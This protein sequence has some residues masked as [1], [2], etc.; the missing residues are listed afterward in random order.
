MFFVSPTSY[1]FVSVDNT[2]D[3]GKDMNIKKYIKHKNS[4]FHF[5]YHTFDLTQGFDAVIVLVIP[6]LV[7][8]DP[9]RL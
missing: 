5:A 7:C 4:L 3:H 6:E 1:V 2:Q 9:K 8:I